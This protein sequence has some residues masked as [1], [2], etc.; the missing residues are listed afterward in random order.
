MGSSRLSPRQTTP[1]ITDPNRVK[2]VLERIGQTR[3]CS[4]MPLDGLVVRDHN[5]DNINGYRAS[6][7]A[8]VLERCT[9]RK[10]DLVEADL[11]F[12][13]LSEVDFSGA[14]L[15]FANLQN[16]YL[17]NA[18]FTNANLYGANLYAADISGADFAN[19][20]LRNVAMLQTWSGLSKNM[21]LVI[22]GL[23]WPIQ[24]DKK[25]NLSIGDETFSIQQWERMSTEELVGLALF[26]DEE[27][28]TNLIE[29]HWKGFLAFA[30]AFKE[31]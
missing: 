19:T 7:K 20:D 12:A 22:H 23:D 13:D 16:A 3:S 25:G 28:V 26:S 6:F 21:P 31:D 9:F 1:Q 17:C 14:D 18:N 2:Q 15:R 24:L 11:S 10:A 5:F 30:K 29:K 4:T 8:A 27:E